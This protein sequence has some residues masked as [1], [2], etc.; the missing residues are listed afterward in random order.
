MVL[1]VA[2]AL[3]GLRFRFLFLDLS[4]PVALL[5]PPVLLPPPSPAVAGAFSDM[6]EVARVTVGVLVMD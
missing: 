6:F 5:L 4:P 1:E 3:N 2:A